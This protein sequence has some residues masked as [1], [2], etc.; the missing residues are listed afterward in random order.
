MRSED[1]TRR[2]SDVARMFN[3]LEASNSDLRRKLDEAAK[4]L[5]EYEGTDLASARRV[6]REERILRGEAETRLA[7]A[8]GAL[9][10]LLSYV[11]DP[12][13]YGLTVRDCL[14]D[15]MRSFADAAL[16][17]QPVGPPDDTQRKRVLGMRDEVEHLSRWMFTPQRCAG[18]WVSGSGGHREHEGECENPATWSFPGD[19]FAYCDKHIVEHDKEWYIHRP[20]QPASEGEVGR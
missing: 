20:S 2:P 9:R 19:M 3:E 13:A 6:M 17:S 7:S 8:V 11:P 10:L 14:S 15:D 16:A 12:H 18:E 5:A 1:C 4:A